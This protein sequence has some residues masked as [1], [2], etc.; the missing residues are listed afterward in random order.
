MKYYYQT[1]NLTSQ[2]EKVNASKDISK[3]VKTKK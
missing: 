1:K 3:S 2:Q